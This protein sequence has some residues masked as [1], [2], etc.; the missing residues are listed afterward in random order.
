MS[1]EAVAEK[2]P[3][4]K[5]LDAT[6][7]Q[8]IACA[9]A[10][11]Q[12]CHRVDLQLLV[13]T[14]TVVHKK[15]TKTLADAG[16]VW[17]NAF[18]PEFGAV[19]RE[20]TVPVARLPGEGYV[21]VYYE[22]RQRWDVWQVMA[23]A[24][25]RKI[26]H[27]VSAEQYRKL[28]VGFV[29]VE[30]PKA[31][32]QGAANHPA[33]LI[34]IEGAS[35]VEKAW[36]AYSAHL[37]APMVLK[38]YANNP[39]VDV[40]GPDGKPAGKK[41]LRELRGRQ[42]TPKTMVTAAAPVAGCMPLDKGMLASRVVDFSDK[43]TPELKQ[44]FQFSLRPLDEARLGLAHAFAERVRAIERASSPGENPTLYVD[45]SRIVMLPDDIGAIEEYNHLRLTAKEARIAWVT[46]G[47][48]YNDKNDD[49]LRPW[50]LASSSHEEMIEASIFAENLAFWQR[51]ADLGGEVGRVQRTITT[52]E[53]DIIRSQ[54]SKGILVDPPGTQYVKVSDNWVRV[55]PPKE[56]LDKKLEE[57]AHEKSKERIERCRG[58]VR[59]KEL[60]TFRQKFKSDVDAWEKYV[61]ALDN[62][63]V[64]WLIHG[65]LAVTI[66]HD[67]DDKI[68]L[69]KLD[70]GRGTVTQQIAD[71]MERIG[72]VDKAWGGGMLSPASAKELA[73]A[74]GKDP[75]A[76]ATWIGKAML[77]P[78]SYAKAIA[79]DAGKQKDI[80]ERINALSRETPK[81]VKEGLHA[82]HRIHAQR[83]ES[84]ALAS[85]QAA[86]L[87]AS[88]VDAEHAKAMGLAP[89]SVDEAKRVLKIE[90]RTSEIINILTDPAAEP[91]V[92]FKVKLGTGEV[93]DGMAKAVRR[94]ALE[95]AFSQNKVEVGM[96]PKANTTRQSRRVVKND[97]NALAGRKGLD[98]PEFH[99]VIVTEKALLQMEKEAARTGE[100][101]VEVIA[102]DTLGK[103]MPTAFRV[104]KSTALNL[105]GKQMSATRATMKAVWSGQGAV[106]GVLA[107]FQVRSLLEALDKLEKVDGYAHTDTLMSV[108]TS[109]TGLTEGG[110]NIVSG[111]F[112]IRAS[113]SRLF[114][115][116]TMTRA[117]MVRL[118]AG[119][120]GAAG[121]AFDAVAA[122]ARYQSAQNRGSKAAADAY[123][124]SFRSFAVSG[125]AF[126]AGTGLGFANATIARYAVSRWV[127]GELG[128][129]AVAELVGA[130]F[131]GIGI[132][133]M[134]AG[135]AWALYAESLEDDLVDIFLKRSYWGDGEAPSAPFGASAKPAQGKTGES[136]VQAKQI[137]AETGMKE[138]YDGFSALAIGF[139]ASV[140]WNRHW[141]EDD[142]L[143]ARIEGA[144]ESDKYKVNFD[145]AV[146]A[147]DGR[148]L[149]GL[150]NRDVPLARDEE[151]GHYMLDIKLPLYSGVWRAAK[152]ARF[153]YTVFDGSERAQIS[154]D[155][156][157][158]DKEKP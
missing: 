16:Y 141:F 152:T 43:R 79:E 110:L 68:N 21:Y 123:Q 32:S 76:P 8:P 118:A 137:W 124:K 122:Y 20:A 143:A 9:G 28:Q 62:D 94:K 33:H 85:Q 104:P 103:T 35:S 106:S 29:N 109:V 130:S 5:V 66:G 133:L 151:S 99:P 31:C 19:K 81:L 88:L 53:Y 96:E 98:I 149:T 121:S 73:K 108:F 150:S 15:Y 52:Y 101:V 63:F 107:I 111:Y 129:M 72:A 75:A 70:E 58:K 55:I 136:A 7:G 91:H 139:K 45:K 23:S 39:M 54:Q 92:T 140:E 87:Q 95:E 84:L 60:T 93:L 113:G 154:A 116:T 13:V 6:G 49:A 125:A 86:L 97:L 64:A 37:W 36:L 11:C 67:F 50:K 40:P 119:I 114:L 156:L 78:F 100:E 4:A 115:G 18:D 46:G 10:A 102:D 25:T 158:V 144:A 48:D 71:V 157:L 74:Y 148:H 65:R 131:T 138:E 83:L 80:A 105:I 120:A 155:T 57:K 56:V 3:A 51:I 142:I 126:V 147:E 61:A 38:R 112:T 132:V 90:C 47:P 117:A 41:K 128:G 12:P 42:L 24:L 82:A 44:A 146:V 27:Q 34:C 134:V 127:V 26:M 135:F 59:L 69:I 89:V 17:D 145:V 77:E 30:P 22:D 153:T 2:K 1:A 14:P